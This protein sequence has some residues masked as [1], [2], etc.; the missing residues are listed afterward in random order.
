MKIKS[1]EQLI[2]EEVENLMEVLTAKISDISK[3]DH[4]PA[5]SKEEPAKTEP[6]KEPAKR[7]KSGGARK[8]WEVTPPGHEKQVKALKKELPKTYTDDSGERKESSP[9]ALAWASYNKEHS[10]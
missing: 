5:S 8:V 6:K 10:K 2:K 4:Q 1:L 3:I 9:W 7:R